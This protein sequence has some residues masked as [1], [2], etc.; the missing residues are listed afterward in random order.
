V[1]HKMLMLQENITAL[2]KQRG[3]AISAAAA[4]CTP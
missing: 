4:F 1:R 3:P 2:R